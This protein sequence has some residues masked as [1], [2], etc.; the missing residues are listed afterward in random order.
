MASGK[1]DSAD[2]PDPQPGSEPESEF[3]PSLSEFGPS[4]NDFGPAPDLG[5]AGWTPAPVPQNP[6][7]SWRPADAAPPVPPPPAQ[8]RAPDSWMP[9][10]TGQYPAVN[11]SS[12]FGDPTEVT[13]KFDAPNGSPQMGWAPATGQFPAVTEP[14][15]A[16]PEAPKAPDAPAPAPAEEADSTSWWRSS[17]P[18]GFPPTPPSTPESS[19]TEGESLSWADDPIAKML[20]PKT[21]AKVT[22]PQEDKPDRPVKKIAAIAVGGVALVAVIGVAAV[23]MLSGGGDKDDTQADPTAGG[24]ATAAAPT[25]AAA[26]SCPSK[27]DGNL[28]IGNGSGSTRTG[29]EAILGFQHAFYTDRSGVKA[30]S[31][32]APD[33]VNVST[34]EVIQKDGID[35]TPKGVSYCVRIVEVAPETYDADLTVHSPDGTTAVYPQRITTVDRE[36][37]HLIFALEGR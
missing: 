18:T 5:A 4:L 8:Y 22:P 32:V 16:A 7:L 2:R 17:S 11:G 35:P 28:T 13:T 30:R 25:T 10:T 12:P 15:P 24:P 23:A 31:F 6:D 1:D 34:A 19:G 21:A 9:P 26:L 14:V 33:S 20:A 36:G 29:A 27:R 37:K 3:G